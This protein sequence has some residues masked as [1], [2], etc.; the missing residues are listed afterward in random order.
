MQIVLQVAT[1][2]AQSATDDPTTNRVS[3]N[4]RRLGGLCGLLRGSHV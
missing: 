1:N 2:V 3:V 4:V